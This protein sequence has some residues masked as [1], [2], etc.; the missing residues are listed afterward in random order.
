MTILSLEALMALPD[1]EDGYAGIYFLWL[2]GNLQYVGQS[3]SVAN[4]IT[5]HHW[6]YMYGAQ[7]AQPVARIRFDK[8]TYLELDRSPYLDR[9]GLRKLGKLLI[10]TEA[11]YVNAYRT[12]F[13]AWPHRAT[14]VE[15]GRCT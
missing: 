13:N 1:A 14:N 6:N 9:D 4:R 2:D 12:P 7:R 5:Q 8:S 10:D 15:L 11:L 3:R